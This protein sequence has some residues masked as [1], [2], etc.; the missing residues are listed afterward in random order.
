[1]T[2]MLQ[3]VVSDGTAK[4]AQI[5]GFEPAGKTGTAEVAND[6]GGYYDDKYNVSFV[7]YLPNTTS[8]FVCFT[9]SIEEPREGNVSGMFRDIMSSAI[10]RYNITTKN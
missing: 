5:D 1:M 6:E 3:T 8:N 4:D 10:S 7:G 9:G 2:S